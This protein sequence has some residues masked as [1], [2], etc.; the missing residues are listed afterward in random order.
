VVQFLIKGNPV[1]KVLPFSILLDNIGRNLEMSLS[2]Y[3]GIIQV[4]DEFV[5]QKNE[6]DQCLLI[7][8]AF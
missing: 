1:A 8:F 3:G 4:I 7:D 5:S 2:L 6:I